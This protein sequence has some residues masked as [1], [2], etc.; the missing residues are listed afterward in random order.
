MGDH[1]EQVSR[2][3]ERAAECRRL[4]Q[5]LSEA[6]GRGPYL[7]L[8]DAYLRLADAYELVASQEEALANWTASVGGLEYGMAR[9]S[10]T[11]KKGVLT[12]TMPKMPNA[13]SK[14]RRIAING[15]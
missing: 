5:L 15:Q 4:S 13:R 8:T 11:L 7:R 2:L 6:S 10:A 14:I 1:K 9:V 3:R 12:V